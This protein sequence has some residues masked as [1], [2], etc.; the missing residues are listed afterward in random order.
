M[1]YLAGLEAAG[2]VVGAKVPIILVS[3][4]SDVL[5]RKA[6]SVMALLYVRKSQGGA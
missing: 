1:T 4:G 6:S 5:S 2:M 3:R